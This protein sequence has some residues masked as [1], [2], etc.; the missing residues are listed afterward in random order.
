M[1][2]E[3]T[4]MNKEPMN[5]REKEKMIV[6]N[7]STMIRERMMT[8]KKLCGFMYK[9]GQGDY[10]KG[11]RCKLLAK[12]NSDYCK[13]HINV[14]SARSTRNRTAE[15]LRW[16][17]KNRMEEENSCEKEKK[18]PVLCSDKNKWS[19]I[20]NFL[21]ST[22]LENNEIVACG[23][24][25]ELV[26]KSC[27]E[28]VDEIWMLMHA[29]ILKLQSDSDD[30]L[31]STNSVPF[32]VALSDHNYSLNA[33]VVSLSDLYKDERCAKNAANE[34]FEDND[35]H[36]ELYREDELQCPLEIEEREEENLQEMLGAGKNMQKFFCTENMGILEGFVLEEKGRISKNGGCVKVV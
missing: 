30:G 18:W 19:C 17:E 21:N 2:K 31:N 32:A 5:V 25:G 7:K 9:K 26:E 1:H 36:Q 3:M 11:D 10:E 16:R 15:K 14:L 27:V 29:G 34:V 4:D 33:S 35:V 22:K 13:V 23:V 12:P 6:T 24:C 28:L 8:E 20:S